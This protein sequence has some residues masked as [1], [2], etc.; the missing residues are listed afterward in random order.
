[1]FKSQVDQIEKLAIEFTQASAIED[2]TPLTL[3]TLILKSLAEFNK[4][5][6]GFE[7]SEQLAY[8]FAALLRSI[9]DRIET[10]DWV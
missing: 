4:A 2:S 1:M 7:D 8:G 3:N 6:G 9:A 10:F 5:D